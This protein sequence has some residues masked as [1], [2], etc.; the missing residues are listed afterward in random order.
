MCPKNIKFKNIIKKIHSMIK[1]S[2]FYL[3]VIIKN[4]NSKISFIAFFKVI[5]Y[6]IYRQRSLVEIREKFFA[7]VGVFHNGFN[8]I[9]GDY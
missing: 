9:Y 4:L 3:K 8:K 2:R 5:Q 7:V 1:M 6:I